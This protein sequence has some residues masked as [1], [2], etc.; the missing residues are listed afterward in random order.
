MSEF[1]TWLRAQLDADADELAG[2]DSTALNGIESTAGPWVR[3][4]VE[5]GLA[6]V[7]A[8]RRILDVHPIEYSKVSDFTDCAACMDVDTY[9]SYPCLT[10]RLLALPYA[11]RPGF[12][13]AWRPNG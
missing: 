12:Q 5:R 11:E 10:V 2:L 1:I 8:E 3:E 13:E 7:E 9:D 6:R 4:Y